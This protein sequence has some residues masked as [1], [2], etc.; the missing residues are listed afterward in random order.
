MDFKP[1][2]AGQFFL[3]QAL[4]TAINHL[5]SYTSQVRKGKDCQ[6]AFAA[7]ESGRL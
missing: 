5:T 4:D 7:E 3:K 6:K 1:I 2:S